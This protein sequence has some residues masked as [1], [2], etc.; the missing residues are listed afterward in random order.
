MR[1]SGVIPALI[2]PF[3]KNFEID[4][5]GF[6]SNIDFVIRGGVSAIVPVGT[7]GEAAT[8]SHEEHKKVIDIAI[9]AAGKV[10]VFAGTG[11]NNTAEAIEL[12]KYAEDAG[13]DAALMITP[14]YNKPNDSGI[15]KHFKAVAEAV[16]IPIILYNI[17]GRTGQNVRPEIIAKLAEIDNIIAIKEASGDLRQVMKIIELCG[18][19]LQVIS[20]DDELTYPIMALGGTGVISVAAN[21]IPK[22]M[23]K[24]VDAMTKGNLKQAKQ[25]H[26]KYL[27]LFKTLF[28]ETNPVPVKEAM[29]MMGLAAG[30]T[31][32]PLGPMSEEN[33]KTLKAVLESYGLLKR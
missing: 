11:S 3:T 9:A 13:S 29:N 28:L 21:I 33:R 24:L 16:N 32:L 15:V 25:L 18:D 10:P 31:R 27:K 2:T 12:T 8:L 7:T 23:C 5:E 4:E 22:Q 26:Y 20:G 6:R 17:P 14:Y 1:V 30:P 19:K